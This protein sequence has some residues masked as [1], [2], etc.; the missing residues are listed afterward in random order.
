MR[1]P[2]KLVVFDADGTLR[3]TIVPGQGCPYRD[4]EWRLMPNVRRT[5]KALR[6]A[7]VPIA[8]ASN[9]EDVALGHLT[10]STA[11]RLIEDAVVRA[12]GRRPADLR[13]EMCTCMPGSGCEC[14]KP[15]PGML[16]R[17]IADFGI[18]P[19]EALFV[20]D[21]DTDRECAERAGARFAWARD[22]FGWSH[23]GAVDQAAQP[24]ADLPPWSLSDVG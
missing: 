20:G 15:A 14:H 12:L 16:R 13:I 10:R 17:L 4:G 9:Q 7:R 2:V 3:W 8:I 18:T 5:L 6:R 21:L 23:P 1:S 19:A 22:V 24:A 11:R